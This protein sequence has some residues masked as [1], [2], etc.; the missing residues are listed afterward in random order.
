[1][2]RAERASPSIFDSDEYSKTMRPLSTAIRKRRRVKRNEIPEAR[3][4]WLRAK[5]RIIQRGGQLRSVVVA[6]GLW[7]KRS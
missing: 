5:T 2:R 3:D 7:P 4:A 1:M 6:Y